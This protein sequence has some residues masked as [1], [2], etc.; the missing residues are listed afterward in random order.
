MS[1]YLAFATKTTV[2]RRAGSSLALI[3]ALSF[4]LQP[5]LLLAQS[6]DP[7]GAAKGKIESHR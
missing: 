1:L 5:T 2:W 4:A 3:G 6:V 7:D